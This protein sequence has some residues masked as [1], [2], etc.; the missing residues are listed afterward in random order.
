MKIIASNSGNF[1]PPHIHLDYSRGCKGISQKSERRK[2]KISHSTKAKYF[3][4]MFGRIQDDSMQI[5]RVNM[6]WNS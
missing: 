5:I 2:R 6:Q 3:S 4:P 1:F